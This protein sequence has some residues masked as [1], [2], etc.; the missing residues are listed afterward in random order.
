MKYQFFGDKLP[1]VTLQFEAGESIFTQPA[2]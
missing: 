2:A 1:I